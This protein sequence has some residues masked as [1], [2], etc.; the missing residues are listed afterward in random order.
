MV[1]E[2]PLFTKQ[3]QNTF[4]Q[5]QPKQ[6]SFDKRNTN[7]HTWMKE[8]DLISYLG[9]GLNTVNGEL[10]LKETEIQRHSLEGPG[11]RV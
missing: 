3:I 1:V 8:N 5:I 4:L 2:I 7:D 11:N 9:M 6:K 10:L